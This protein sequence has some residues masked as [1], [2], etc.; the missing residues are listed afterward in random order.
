MSHSDYLAVYIQCGDVLKSLSIHPQSFKISKQN[1]FDSPITELASSGVKYTR[2]P[3]G[4]R[5]IS[6]CSMIQTCQVNWTITTPANTLAV[7]LNISTVEWNT[8]AKL[9]ART[10]FN[11][12]EDPTAERTT[13][14]SQATQGYYG[15]KA[16]GKEKKDHLQFWIGFSRACGP[17]YQFQL[18]KDATAL[19]GSAIYARESAVINGNS[20]SDLCTKN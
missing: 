19:W 2:A 18:M 8:L 7:Q 13:N 1:F 16:F 15:K 20:L 9:N 17:F 11:S 10:N 5:G 6:A 14:M 3:L 4:A 12:K